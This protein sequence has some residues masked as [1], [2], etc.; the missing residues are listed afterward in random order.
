VGRGIQGDRGPAIRAREAGWPRERGNRRPPRKTWALRHA[1][2]HRR[3]GP[4]AR[5]HRLRREFVAVA[6]VVVSFLLTSSTTNHRPYLS[7]AA[8]TTSFFTQLV[9]FLDLTLSFTSDKPEEWAPLLVFALLLLVVLLS[10]GVTV[11]KVL[12]PLGIKNGLVKG[13]AMYGKE[14]FGKGMP[15]VDASAQP[16]P[17][18]PGEKAEGK[19]II[20]PTNKARKGAAT[21][22]T[23]EKGEE[24]KDAEEEDK[25]QEGDSETGSPV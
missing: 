11:K 4:G 23:E 25:T 22:T 17:I 24:L 20:R 13:G 21:E 5:R 15:P 12:F 9:W 7:H 6:V 3:A 18:G 10:V 1:H 2:L 8:A 16:L 19:E 14:G